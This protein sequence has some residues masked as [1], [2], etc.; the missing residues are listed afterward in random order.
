MGVV[1]EPFMSVG[2]PQPAIY[3]ELRVLL[4]LSLYVELEHRI[5]NLKIYKI[6]LKTQSGNRCS[7]AIISLYQTKP[8]ACYSPGDLLHKADMIFHQIQRKTQWA[9]NP[10]GREEAH[11]ISLKHTHIWEIQVRLELTMC[12][13]HHQKN[14]AIPTVNVQQ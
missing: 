9:A 1:C 6:L 14:D 2:A 8:S 4:G 12:I 13:Q 5:I 3:R 7:C 10:V 11:K